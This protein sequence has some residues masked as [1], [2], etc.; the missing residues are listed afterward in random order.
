MTET[1]A[2]NPHA[3]RRA[4]RAGR[5]RLA[6][7]TSAGSKALGLIV[8]FL[9]IPLAVRSLGPE[10]FGIYMMLFSALVWIDLGR[11]GIGP[12][13]TRELGLAWNRGERDRERM[14]FSNAIFLLLAIAAVISAALT[15]GYSWGAEYIDILFGSSA[16]KYHYDIVNGSI[17][18][19]IFLVAQI[20]FSAGEA[21][22]SAYQDDFINNLMNSLA[23]FVSLML[24]F[25]VALFWPTVPAFA[26]AVFGTIALGKGLNLALLLLRS[27][28]YL[29]PRWRY[30]QKAEIR[31]LLGSSLAFWLLQIG[32]VMM[33][34]L[35]LVQLGQM[36]GAGNLAP[37][38]LVFRLLQLL[39]TAVLMISMPLW[40]AITD[41]TVRGDVEWILRAYRRLIRFATAFSALTAMGIAILGSTL[42]PLWA[43]GAVR[44]GFAL[45]A[46]L[47]LYFVIWMWNHCHTVILFGLGKLWAVAYVT[48]AEGLSVLVLAALLVPH[49]GALGTAI[50]L[51]GAGLGFS[52]WI[53]PLLVRSGLAGLRVGVA[54][55]PMASDVAASTI[56]GNS[57]V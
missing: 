29:F 21:A 52:A 24:L 19:G 39:S 38:A 50:A 36:I 4:F 22:R 44:P 11:L 9:A 2:D 25:G 26:L 28:P 33:H 54:V 57:I 35:S 13:L 53:L 30:V 34:H 8:Q 43:G 56:P 7:L 18:V 31:P 6:F 48:L 46:V 20:V 32:T 16:L 3:E 14:L 55:D 15:L 27:R 1:E 42:I 45:N 17:V 23:N 51:C 5:V 10:R 37:F 41:A 49:F 47:G 40:P 12:G